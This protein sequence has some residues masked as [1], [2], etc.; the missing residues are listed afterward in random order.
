MSYKLLKKNDMPV[1]EFEWG[2]LMWYANSGMGQPD[3]TL[4]FCYINQGRQNYTHMHPNC[5]ETLHVL[6]G[7]VLHY[8]GDEAVAMGEG[9]TI[10]IPANTVH[11]ARNIGTETAVLSIAFS[12]GDRETVN[13]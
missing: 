12:S 1:G 10:T 7:S 13:A 11:S 4:G 8:V 6:K 9:D 3:Y 2:K 5:T